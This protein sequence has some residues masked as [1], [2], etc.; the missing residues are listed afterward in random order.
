MNDHTRKNEFLLFKDAIR[1]FD[2]EFR[3]AEAHLSGRLRKYSFLNIEMNKSKQI[4]LLLFQTKLLND[5]SESACC[6]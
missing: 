3:T 2:D 1:K 4:E 6:A 5:H